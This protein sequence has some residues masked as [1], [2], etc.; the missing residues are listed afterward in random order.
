MLCMAVL[1]FIWFLAASQQSGKEVDSLIS[2]VA[3]E[4]SVISEK[5]SADTEDDTP[6]DSDPQRLLQEGMHAMW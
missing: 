2:A 3:T 6:F 4:L 5:H 1:F